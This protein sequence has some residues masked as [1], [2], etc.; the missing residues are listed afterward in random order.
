[1]IMNI[2]D[3]CLPI[4][5][6]SILQRLI[7]IT[8]WFIEFQ[9]L[10]D[11]RRQTRKQTNIRHTRKETNI[12]RRSYRKTDLHLLIIIIIHN[13]THSFII[14]YPN[15]QIAGLTQHIVIQTH[16]TLSTKTDDTQLA[17]IF[18]GVSRQLHEDDGDLIILSSSPFSLFS[19]VTL[20]LIPSPDLEIQ[21]ILTAGERR[22]M[23][24]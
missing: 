13:S 20:F 9:S 12:K 6:L 21:K 23:T 24:T 1:M 14:L 15:S 11:S 8:T 19:L 22:E 7:L 5:S 10:F 3:I 17:T 16:T 2:H 4:S 18:S